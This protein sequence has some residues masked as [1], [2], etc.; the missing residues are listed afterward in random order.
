MRPATRAVREQKFEEG[1]ALAGRANRLDAELPLVYVV[2]GYYAIN[3]GDYGQAKRFAETRLALA[4][5]DPRAYNNLAGVMLLGGEPNK[6]LDLYKSALELEPRHPFA[7]ILLGRGVQPLRAHCRRGQTSALE[8][9]NSSGAH[10]RRDVRCFT[11]P[12]VIGCYRPS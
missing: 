10:V 11:R 2:L 4:T 5:K 6:A 9:S 7:G 12:G 1:R 8:K 3:H